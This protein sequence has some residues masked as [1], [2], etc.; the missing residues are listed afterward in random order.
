MY[1][2][3]RPQRVEIIDIA[4]DTIGKAAGLQSCRRLCLV[5]LGEQEPVS[6]PFFLIA[7]DCGGNFLISRQDRTCIYRCLL[8]IFGIRDFDIGSD[9]PTLKEGSSQ[10]RAEVQHPIVEYVQN[11]GWLTGLAAGAGR[12]A[13]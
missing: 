12:Q 13:E 11:A 2:I 4:A 6:L 5:E 10:A 1:L 9:P 7:F 3:L 8:R